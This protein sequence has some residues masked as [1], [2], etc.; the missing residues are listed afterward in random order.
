MGRLLNVLKTNFDFIL[1]D[2]PPILQ[3]TEAELIAPWVEGVVLVINAH[4]T[5]REVVMRAAERMIQQKEFLGAVFNQQEFIIPQFL[6][7]RLK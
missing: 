1:I 2:S 6:Y 5:R 3:S 7:K 4:T